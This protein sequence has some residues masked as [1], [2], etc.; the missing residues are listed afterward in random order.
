ML[1]IE[2]RGKET[3]AVF[4]EGLEILFHPTNN[5]RLHKA[6]THSHTRAHMH[7]GISS[8]LSAGVKWKDLDRSSEE[9][10]KAEYNSCV[11]VFHLA[12]WCLASALQGRAHNV[13]FTDK[14]TEA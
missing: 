11:V 7:A 1:L 5:P 4:L 8:A 10:R 3:E 2:G 13:H 6:H 12:H 14:E 9:T